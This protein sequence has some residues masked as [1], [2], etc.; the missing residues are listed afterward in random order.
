MEDYRGFFQLS[1]MS[2]SATEEYS[3]AIHG[4]KVSRAG[5][6]LQTRYKKLVVSDQFRS[7]M[8]ER[9]SHQPNHADGMI[10]T[11]QQRTMSVWCM[12]Q[13]KPLLNSQTHL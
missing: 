5:L 2:S 6:R 9:Y 11:I 1:G 12:Q 3:V 13:S 7:C 4:R 10:V 8:P